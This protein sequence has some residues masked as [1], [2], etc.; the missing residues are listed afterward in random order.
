MKASE[1]NMTEEILGHTRFH[2]ITLPLDEEDPALTDG[3]DTMGKRMD[4]I[5]VIDGNPTTEAFRR[6]RF[7]Y[8]RAGPYRGSERDIP[9]P[10]ISEAGALIRTECATPDVLL[11]YEEGLRALIEDRGG[12][13]ET[14]RGVQKPR[15]YTS[16]AMTRYAYAR[17]L[18]PAPGARLPIGVV[19]PQDKTWDWWKMD[20]MRRESF[21]LP[22][23]DRSGRML[24]KGHALASEA[25]ITRIHRR[26][27][28]NPD[29]YGLRDGYDFV[30]YFEFAEKD[31]E[32]FRSV[33]ANLRD[34][35]INPEWDY[36]NEGPEWWGTRVGL[37]KD[38]WKI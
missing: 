7:Q 10:E 37:P 12:S 1:L 9:H 8:L 6:G 35:S 15:S 24:A 22:R 34:E 25:G 2:F 19:T 5:H 33:M 16:Y 31:I 30:G 11:R 3:L 36:V 20:W 23:Y 18:L 21:F 26:L 28:H 27:V 32:T 38:L 14:L 4:N 17:A 29:G 13:V